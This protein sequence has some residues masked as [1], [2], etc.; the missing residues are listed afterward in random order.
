MNPITLDK[1][2]TKVGGKY[3]LVSLYQKRLR[4]LQRGLP[5]LVQAE[6][7]EPLESLVCREILDGKVDLLMGE[8]AEKLRKE[9]AA[10]EADEAEAAKKLTGKGA[11][12]PAA[13]AEAKKAE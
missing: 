9:I 3:R 2:L 5:A 1:M 12:A 8:A 10:R 4:E 11:A 7:E 13:P 6:D